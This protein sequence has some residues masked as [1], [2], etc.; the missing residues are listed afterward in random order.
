LD[1][2]REAGRVTSAVYSPRDGAAI[3]LGYVHRDL[4]GD[5]VELALAGGGRARVTSR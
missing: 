5:G 2:E 4:V 1:G 3:G